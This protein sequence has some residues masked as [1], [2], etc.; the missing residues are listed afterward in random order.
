LERALVVND[1]HRINSSRISHWGEPNASLL[2]NCH[3]SFN[4]EN[5]AFWWSA[6]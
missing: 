4:S 1:K 3:E 2:I 5:S 6:F